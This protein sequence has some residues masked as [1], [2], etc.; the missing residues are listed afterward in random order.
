MVTLSRI[1][2]Q[3]PPT[4]NMGVKHGLSRS[5]NMPS[6]K[7]KRSAHT[8]QHSAGPHDQWPRCF[9]EVLYADSL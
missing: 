1:G 9:L 4:T 7:T 3:G 2:A 6:L 8:A 5:Y